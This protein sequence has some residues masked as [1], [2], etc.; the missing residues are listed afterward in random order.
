MCLFISIHC[1]ATLW[2][3][4]SAVPVCI[5]HVVC[6]VQVCVGDQQLE[7]NYDSGK[8]ELR[9]KTLFYMYRV[10]NMLWNLRKIIRRIGI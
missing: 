1:P 3:P 8:M 4:R 5:A 10:V 7:T 2:K 9:T 6:R